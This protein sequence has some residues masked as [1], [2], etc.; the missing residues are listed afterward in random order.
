MGVALLQSKSSPISVNASLDQ[1]ASQLNNQPGNGGNTS[2]KKSAIKTRIK[3][4][5]N[6]RVK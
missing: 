1:N 3:S 6:K 5:P 4:V 2:S